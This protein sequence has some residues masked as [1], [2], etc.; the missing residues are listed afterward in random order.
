MD[1]EDENGCSTDPPGLR[2]GE[3]GGP[4]EEGQTKVSPEDEEICTVPADLC[5]VQVNGILQGPALP[6]EDVRLT[7]ETDGDPWAKFD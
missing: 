4:V 3:A 5:T 2:V 1:P 6:P 7:D